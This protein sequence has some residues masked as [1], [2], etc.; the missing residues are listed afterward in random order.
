MPRR[1][2]HQGARCRLSFG[3]I[4]VRL[5]F[6]H[7]SYRL[8]LFHLEGT[9]SG[10]ALRRCLPS[11]CWAPQTPLLTI[12]KWEGCSWLAFLRRQ[13]YIWHVDQHTC[14]SDVSHLTHVVGV[15]LLHGGVNTR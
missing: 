6:L 9:C 10:A 3:T 8:C 14:H 13:A 7:L 5:E 11:C 2:F 15:P 1:Q 12:M 4:V